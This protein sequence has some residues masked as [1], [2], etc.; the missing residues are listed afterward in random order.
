[1][2]VIM[3]KEICSR[4]N[5]ILSIQK[6]KIIPYFSSQVL[7]AS[8]HWIKVTDFINPITGIT[9]LQLKWH[10]P[11]RS[12]FFKKSTDKERILINCL[13]FCFSQYFAAKLN[14]TSSSGQS[15]EA[16]AVYYLNW[17]GIIAQVPNMALSAF[18]LF[19]QK[20]G[21]WVIFRSFACLSVSMHN[22][23]GW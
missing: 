4:I 10:G 21:K 23:D 19:Y 15:G 7:T 13:C 12:A 1:M 14:V 6:A 5:Y 22:C 17:V 8:S 20:K 3:I 11:S 18:N 2:R 9:A 16:Y